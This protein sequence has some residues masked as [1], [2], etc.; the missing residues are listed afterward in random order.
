MI[1]AH[2]FNVRHKFCE[3]RKLKGNLSDREAVVHI[4]FSENYNLKYASEIQACHFGASQ[5]QATLHT[6]IV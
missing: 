5:Q 4:D 6:G 2:V 1:C 3:Y